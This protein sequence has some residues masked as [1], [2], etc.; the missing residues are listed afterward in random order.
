MNRTVQAVAL[1]LVGSL[2][3]D[4][5]HGQEAKPKSS[6]A[7]AVTYE[8]VEAVLSK[9]CAGCHNANEHEG[10]F[11]ISSYASL[12]KGSD[13]GAVIVGGSI[14]KSK[15]LNMLTGKLDPAMPPKEE[16]QPST[17][18]IALLTRWVEQGANHVGAVPSQQP[19]ITPPQ[20]LRAADRFLHVGSACAVDDRSYAIGSFKEVQLKG[21]ALTQPLWIAGG[22]SGKVN[23]LRLSSNGRWLIAGCGVAGV[24]G[25]ALVLDVKDGRVI[26]R[27]IGHK[28]AIY[29]ASLSPDQRTLATGSYDRNVILWDVSSGEKIR[30]LS[31]H[32]GAI[33][34]L[35]FDPSGQLL[36]TAS[37]DQTIK[38]WQVST[39]QRL[40]TLGQPEGEQ[41]C[42][43]FGP[44]GQTLLAAGADKQ[45]R[46]WQVVSRTEP[47]INPLL[48][49]RFAHEADILQLAFD[50]KHRLISTSSDLTVKLWDADHIVGL[51]TLAQL[52]DVPVGLCLSPTDSSPSYV[53]Q[54]DGKQVALKKEVLHNSS[55]R[56]DQTRTVVQ[57][58]T[59]SELPTRPQ[60]S[61]EIAQA[62][63]SEPNNEPQQAQPIKLPATISGTIAAPVENKPDQDLLRFHALAGE[64][65]ILEVSA[66]GQGSPLDSRIDVLDASGNPVLRTRL[67]ATRES[68]FTFR[69]KDSTTSDDFRLHKWEDMELDEY[70]YANGEV[71]RLWHY[72]RGPDSGFRVYPGAGERHS[73]FDTTPLSHA[74]GQVTY[75]VR[76]LGKDEVPLPNG[77]PVI[78][79][80]FEN[81]DDSQK[82][83]GK[84]SRLTFVAPTSGDYLLRIRDA[85]GFG[86]E[87]SKYQV[88]LRRPHPDFVL[89]LK[90]IK[91]SLPIQ[92]GREWSAEATR[93][94]GLVG[95][96][97]I[98]LDGLPD[99]V[100]A[101]NPLIIE[102]EQQSAVGAVYVSQAALA[103]LGEQKQ[104]EIKLAVTAQA[105]EQTI[106]RVLTEK[107][108]V[109]ITE[110]E[111]VQVR[112]F[113]ANDPTREIDQLD[114][115][116]GQTI[117][118]RVLVERNGATNR[119]EL[120]NDSAGRNLPHGAF[121]DNIGLNGLL[122]PEG[123]T[124]REFFI[125]AAPK[126]APGRRQFH[127]K[128]GTTG[129]PTSRPVWLNVVA[130]S[131]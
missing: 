6:N 115:Q 102:A 84:D 53:M 103:A 54:L 7:G 108:S 33:Y 99:G 101:T 79:V 104:F 81:D 74:L 66:A 45:I 58:Q 121:V 82:R 89:K 90:D 106:E 47:A 57:S 80:F 71:C 9:Y 105:G 38:L 30:E 48:E 93:I 17:E 91:M 42:V 94:D 70:L 97:T 113:H 75:I 64:T 61:A 83:L 96:I 26:Q 15:L 130:P 78:P 29:C 100:Q 88:T 131:K 10:G 50:D 95:P 116:P 44:A 85:R 24:G 43:R 25:E 40:D 31:G 55:N 34:D 3:I 119:I 118:A 23:S 32:N 14:E 67:Q 11:S 98:R 39:G 22:L 129:N 20:L 63:E 86:G 60:P 128:S 52:G 46:Q 28:D 21:Y 2:I 109:S 35:D 122:I 68:Y 41:R 92:S 62:K 87:D 69:G 111:E 8:Q 13:D 125:T 51:G 120:G 65:W 114:I 73:F 36:A 16:P 77:L 18:D 4:R 59:V 127:L 19:T 126:V 112:L 37:A 72:P 107:L 1:L 124:E 27:F 110:A 117:S 12:M 56:P 49:A 123:Q 5:G 76:E